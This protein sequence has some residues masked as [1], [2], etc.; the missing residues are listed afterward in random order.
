MAGPGQD[1]RLADS[2]VARVFASAA[3]C[4]CTSPGCT[5]SAG[6]LPT[7]CGA[8]AGGGIDL[9]MDAAQAM[10]LGDPDLLATLRNTSYLSVRPPAWDACTFA[11]VARIQRRP[12]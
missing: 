7:L 2:A 10:L 8:R 6:G 11:W 4:P 3:A 1:V 12:C 5:Q 9:V